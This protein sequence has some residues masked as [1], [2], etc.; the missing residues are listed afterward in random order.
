MHCSHWYLKEIKSTAKGAWS[1]TAVSQ[2]LNANI[3]C[4]ASRNTQLKRIGQG[5]GE[6]RGIYDR[7]CGTIDG[8]PPRKSGRG[9]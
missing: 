9:V 5:R 2:I 4:D 6:R 3:S 7:D 8:T 1:R